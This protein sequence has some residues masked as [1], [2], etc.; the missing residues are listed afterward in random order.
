MK[1]KVKQ[2]ADTLKVLMNQVKAFAQRM[3]EAADAEKEKGG[4][5]DP[6]DQAKIQ[7]SQLQAQVKAKNASESHAQKTAQRQI[8]FEQK[9]KQDEQSHQLEMAT[10]AQK[11]ALEI[12]KAQ[13]M[14]KKPEGE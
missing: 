10:Q 12:E 2:Y 14:A 13:A 8:S 11:D 3:Q 6:K 7:A 1:Q 9:T 4:G 5:M